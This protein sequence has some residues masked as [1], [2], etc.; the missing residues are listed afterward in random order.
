MAS[1][2]VKPGRLRVPGATL[3]GRRCRNG[4]IGTSYRS[5]AG[6]IVCRTCRALKQRKYTEADRQARLKARRERLAKR[7]RPHRRL[8]IW[9]AG[10]FEGEGTITIRSEGHADRTRPEVS[11]VSTDAQIVAV[12][13]DNWPG[14]IER[15]VPPSKNGL[16]REAFIWKRNATEQVEAFLLD[17]RPYLET[18]RMRSK[19]ALLLEDI[20]DRVQL[21]L[22]S[23][24]KARLLRRMARMR[25]MNRRGI[26]PEEKP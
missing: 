22:T 19:A 11:M 26:L 4:H 8:R 23:D 9:A 17:L 1:D 15:Y 24:R 25:A 12:F 20:R 21:R 5:A 2:P 10:L 13:Q 6:K 18:E 3:P 14:R 16:A 7:K